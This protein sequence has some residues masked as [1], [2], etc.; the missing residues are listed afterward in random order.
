MTHADIKL[1]DEADDAKFLSLSA[2][3]MHNEEDNEI[4][5]NAY[6]K[7]IKAYHDDPVTYT[8]DEVERELGLI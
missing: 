8:L 1:I 6:E 3:R 7:A 5:L 4:A 2:E